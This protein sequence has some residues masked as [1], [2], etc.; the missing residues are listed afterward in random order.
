MKYIVLRYGLISGFLNAAFLTLLIIYGKD[1]NQNPYGM[2]MGFAAMLLAMI[3][4][5]LGIFS[6]AKLYPDF[7]F[8]FGKAFLAGLII[9]FISAMM[10]SATW[11]VLNET[12][13]PDFLND[14]QAAQLDKLKSSGASAM[15][16]QDATLEAESFA[17]MYANPLFKFFITITEVLPVG[18]V[19]A[20]LAALVF[21]RKPLSE[22]QPAV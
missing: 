1:H 18:F 19:C 8:R 7:P 5:F 15:E 16:L 3:P 12:V 2:L 22:N 21:K 20:L 4:L 14:Y 13:Y 17:E 10:Y 11:M 6:G 9:C